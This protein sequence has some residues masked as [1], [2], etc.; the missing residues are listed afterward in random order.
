MA[1]IAFCQSKSPWIGT[2]T[3]GTV[4]LSI[5]RVEPP[6]TSQS[7]LFVWGSLTLGRLAREIYVKAEPT[8]I[9]GSGRLYEIDIQADHP[10]RLPVLAVNG[11]RLLLDRETD[12]LQLTI[13]GMN[14]GMRQVVKTVHLERN[15]E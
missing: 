9:H 4:T 3:D 6:R 10:E 1:P 11:G 15:E 5:T 2:W 7:S 13:R 12:T 14:K 8:A